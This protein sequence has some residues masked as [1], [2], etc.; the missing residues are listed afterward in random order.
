MV[1][2]LTLARAFTILE[3]HG[4][5]R[6]GVIMQL[7]FGTGKMGIPGKELLVSDYR[8]IPGYAHCYA[9]EVWDTTLDKQLERFNLKP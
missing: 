3:K 1:H 8:G 9:L 6:E 7:S 5:P 2:T 4:F